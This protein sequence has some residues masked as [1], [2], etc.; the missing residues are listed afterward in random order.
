MST[1]LDIC[2]LALARLG[3]T[4]TVADITGTSTT[5]EEALCKLLY[6]IA[7]DYVLREAPWNF[8]LKTAALAGST[9]GPSHW[10]YQY[11]YPSDCIRVVKV[12]GGTSP[13]VDE[14][15]PFEVFNSGSA[16]KIATQQASAYA[17]YVMQVTDP[18]LFDSQFISALA[19]YL[20]S[21]LSV[22]LSASPDTA[23]RL[24]AG[25][26][27]LK[28]SF[29]AEEIP[30]ASITANAS[31]TLTEVAIANAALLK[32]G[33][34][35][36][37][38]SST[39]HTN[40]SRLF[41]IYF[42]RVR[43]SILR[44]VPW[45][46]ASKRATL[47]T[48]STA[49]AITGWS[50]KYTVP[51]DCLMA[52]FITGSGVASPKFE[53]VHDATAG[54]VL[55]SNL[56]GAV[57][58]YTAQVTDEA[59]FDPLFTAA[60]ISGLAVAFGSALNVDAKL[61]QAA[62]ASYEQIIGQATLQN[63]KEGATGVFGG[64]VAATPTVLN[65][66]NMALTKLSRSPI[67]EITEPTKEARTLSLFYETVLDRVLKAVPWN[68]ATRRAQ[69]TENTSASTPD[70]WLYVYNYPS[71]CVQALGL[72]VLGTRQP[73]NSE[74]TPFEISVQ[75]ISAADTKLI[76]CDVEPDTTNALPKLIYV[77]R[78]GTESLF[79][80]LFANAMSW[81]LAAEC[82][83]A[84]G[85][86]PRSIDGFHRQYM[87]ALHEA[88]ARNLNEGFEGPDPDSEFISVR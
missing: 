25:Y 40:E 56:T 58:S 18:T 16:R 11:D 81:L 17:Q 82:G 6:P 67:Y 71:D 46:F 78:M 41:N 61:L 73:R 4:K 28:A 20:A 30:R 8:A 64:L 32:V 43:D 86:D 47:A 23:E 29:P 14:P 54:R 10:T 72:E 44:A 22:S 36:T 74:R 27:K 53:V 70:N 50:Y 77:S 31:D 80:P 24:R 2:N 45:N 68:F 12:L 9:T 84:L 66:C 83:P 52:R 87:R 88:G 75:T 13:R 51:S 65:I 42:A 34:S 37:I 57:L 7:R 39:E 5:N 60:L 62:Q 19:M 69:L 1:A 3:S 55:H 38:S 33:H 85:A 79:D 26:E 35:R 59:Q 76:Y 48:A 49:A 15:Q 21:E 63:D